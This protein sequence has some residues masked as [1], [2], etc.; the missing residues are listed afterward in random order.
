MEVIAMSL[1]LLITILYMIQIIHK[2]QK[3][4]FN[5]TRPNMSY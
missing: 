5:N 1:K 4:L 2:L 3:L